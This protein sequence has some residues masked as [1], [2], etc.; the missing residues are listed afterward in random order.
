MKIATVNYSGSVGKTV[1]TSH[2]LAPR[3]PDAEIIAVEST[4]ESAA[5]LGLDVEQ[6]RGGQFGRLFRKLLMAEAAIVDVGASNIEDFLAELVKYDQAHLEIDYYVL[7]VVSSGKAQRETIK[8]I[9][10]LS[11]MGVPADRVRVLFNRVDS[12]VREEFAAIFGYARK[13]GD[14]QANPEAAIFENEVF[15]LLANK[16]TT[17]KE[18]LADPRDYRQELRQADRDDAKLVSHLS[19]MHALQSL[20]RP[21]DRQLDKAFGALFL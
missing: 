8:T 1:T 17:I 15:D 19:D 18:I 6:M 9:Q 10:A 21:V 20:A 13:S 3:I 2:L 4:N 16:R 7:P 11:E 5:D 14:F 12:D